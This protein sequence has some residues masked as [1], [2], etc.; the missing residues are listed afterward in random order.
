MS[1]I[2]IGIIREGKTPPDFRVPLSPEQCVQLQ[3]QY[4]QVK[5]TVQTSPIRCFKDEAYTKLGL[6]VQED[7]SHC[8]I[9]LGVKEVQKEQ[10]IANKTYLFF[11]HT[12][13]KQPYNRAL[14]QE[15][16]NKQIRLV[17]YEVLKDAQNKRI[18]GFGRYAGI[19]GAYNGFL[20]YGLQTKRFKLK[21]AHLC[22][23]RKEVESELKKVDLPSNFRCVLTGFGKVGH[24]A[25]EIISLLPIKE[26]S[27]ESFIN[28]AHHEPVFTHLDTHE[29]FARKADNGFEKAE[30]Y[31]NPEIYKS[32]FEVFSQKADMYIPC[33]F[34]SAKSP[35]I[36]TNDMLRSP[37]NR[38]KTVA[39]ISCDIAGPIACTIRPSI[40]GDP[41]YGYD[42]QTGLEV[43]FDQADAIA[44]MA[45]DNLPCELPL[46]ASIDFGNQLLKNVFPALLGSDP[47]HIIDKGSE[48]TF[49]GK[50]NTP[51]AYLQD[52]A[53]GN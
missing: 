13:K 23:D 10:L 39:D 42:P 16:L 52:Y 27:A 34:W 14:L 32:N 18:T 17:D 28:E 22:H 5:I 48:T 36:L 41:Y 4:K 35:I 50:L 9:L 44:V 33:H 11:S 49:E 40:I 1:I 37:S 46:D 38:I 26:V 24:G 51:F 31:S 7:L 25:R 19:V 8:D 3:E 12:I 6:L 45:V 53:N 20:T 15:I 47:D 2:N 29:Y 43:P 30:F 21:P